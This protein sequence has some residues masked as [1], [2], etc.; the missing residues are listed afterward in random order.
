MFNNMLMGAAGESIK[1]T[2]GFQ[3]ANSILFNDDDT[4]RLTKEYSTTRS[5]ARLFTV[6]FWIKRGNISLVQNIICQNDANQNALTVQFQS[7]DTFNVLIEDSGGSAIIQRRTT[8]LYRDPHAWYHFHIKIDSNQTDDTSCRVYVNGVEQTDFGTKT[9]PGSAQ[10]TRI[11]LSGGSNQL[12]IGT[13]KNGSSSPLDAY[14]AEVLIL[15]GESVVPASNTG[16]Y[17]DNG[18]WRPVDPSSNTF[19]NNGFY[20]NFASSG[21]DIGDDASGN[22]QDFTPDNTPIQTSDSP[23]TNFTT[24]SSVTEVLGAAVTL[25][26]GNLSAAG[27]AAT[28][29]NRNPASISLQTAAGGK[30]I[31]AV[32]PDAVGGGRGDPWITNESYGGGN[33]PQTQSN[34]WTATIDTSSA[35]IESD[36]GTT[37]TH[38]ISPVAATGDYILCAIDLDNNKVWWG[39]YDVST[40]T[41]KWADNSTGFSGDPTDGGTTANATL[42]GETLSIGVSVYTGRS[43]EVDFG[44]GVH[45]LLSNITI[46]TGYKFINAAN[47]YEASAP[48]IVDGSAY[49]QIST[50]EGN[51]GSKTVPQT[52]NSGFTPDMVWIKDR[53]FGNIGNIF[54]AVRAQDPSNKGLAI[55]AGAEDTNNAGVTFGL[56]D[57]KGTL[58]FTGAGDTGDINNTGRTYVGWQWLGAN[59]T[60]T[61]SGSSGISSLVVSAN[62]TS[63]FSV[64]TFTAQSSGSTGVVAHGLGGQVDWIVVKPRATSSE[65]NDWT[66]WHSGIDSTTSN[67]TRTF[68]NSNSISGTGGAA[69]AAAGTTTFTIPDDG[70]YHDRNFAFYTWRSIPGFSKFGSYV[71]NGNANGPFIETGFSPSWVMFKRVSGSVASW[72][73]YDNARDPFNAAETMS[74][75]ESASADNIG[76]KMD[77]LSNGLK[78]K[79]TSGAYNGSSNTYIYM[80]F[81]VHPFA[82]TTPVT[83]R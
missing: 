42:T 62:T 74:I 30:Y 18:V 64:G 78:I 29:W 23:T 72:V 26:D 33:N 46:P 32:K 34:A 7:D 9:N 69:I 55:D 66:V 19:G 53:N 8:A 35:F 58:G 48:A 39:L 63:G 24:L 4:E 73:I 27:T 83:A 41:T 80:A 11:L 47:L 70:Y 45:D 52:G 40:D 2:G 22:N 36:A 15:D 31:W 6:S 13:G 43:C 3:V 68:L 54:D 51:S 14:L 20:L 10:D 79:G 67:T 65:G 71:G 16:E 21:A 57:G 5:S 17:D 82:G 59:G 1:S 75:V 25:S 81:A 50:W 77:W 12:H 44:Q 61:P 60:A 38:A 28:V 49:M 37:T 76:N 56:A